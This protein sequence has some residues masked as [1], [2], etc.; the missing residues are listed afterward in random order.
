MDIADLLPRSYEA[1]FLDASYERRWECLKPIIVQLYMG[2]YGNN[3]KSMTTGQVVEFMKDKY[4][5]YAA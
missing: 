5:F 4:S 3:G 2:K 1:K